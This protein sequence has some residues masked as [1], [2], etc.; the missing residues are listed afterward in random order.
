MGRPLSLSLAGLAAGILAGS[1]LLSPFFALLIGLAVMLPIALPLTRRIYWQE[2]FQAVLT[3]LLILS[4]TGSAGWLSMR[5]GRYDAAQPDPPGAFIQGR[6]AAY[7]AVNERLGHLTVKVLREW[8]GARWRVKCG[9]VLLLVRPGNQAY[10]QGDTWVFGPL[11]LEK[12]PESSPNSTFKPARYWFSRGVGYQGWLND[13]RARPDKPC[14][15][16]PFAERFK[17]WQ[18]LFSD[19]IAAMPVSRDCAGLLSAMILGDRSDLDPELRNEFSR[20]GIIHVLSVS[21]LHVG[22]I[23]LILKKLFFLIGLKRRRLPISALS[24]L[25]VWAY[26]GLTGSGPSAVRAGGMITIFEIAWLMKRNNNGLQVLGAAGFIHLAIDPYTLF[27]AGA[28]LSYLAVA[29]IFTWSP[30]FKGLKNLRFPFNKISGPIT[31]SI[32]AQSLLLPPLIF[33]FGWFPVYFLAGNL[34]LVPVMIAAFYLGIALFLMD[35][36]GIQPG[37]LYVV[38]D[39]LVELAVKGASILGNLP[40]NILEPSGL[41][42]ADI[43]FYYLILLLLRSYFQRPDSLKVMLILALML[44]AVALH[45]LF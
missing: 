42:A 19:R 44:S 37:F 39:R 3:I 10:R 26:V 15:Q 9:K 36:A 32:S 11:T 2:A 40:G 17:R 31:V 8:D 43:P 34:L 21:G 30:V 5:L 4:L 18:Q 12:V 24:L 45:W 16:L 35:L 23:Y 7:R 25:L 22:I 13:G 29:G 38:V 33:W 27:S 14:R 28:Q 6:V 41:W 1:G 20:A